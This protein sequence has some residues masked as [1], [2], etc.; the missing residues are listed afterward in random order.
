MFGGWVVARRGHL[1]TWLQ[2]DGRTGVWLPACQPAGHPLLPLSRISGRILWG[3]FSCRPPPQPAPLAV[4][5]RHLHPCPA[6]QLRSLS[7][8]AVQCQLETTTSALGCLAA[9]TWQGTVVA[10]R[11]PPDL[12]LLLAWAA[13]P[14]CSVAAAFD[15]P[16]PP[17]RA[18]AGRAQGGRGSAGW[19]AVGAGWLVR[20]GAGATAAP[21]P[22]CVYQT[23]EDRDLGGAVWRRRELLPATD[24]SGA[25][26]TT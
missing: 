10:R 21:R 16:F 8:S 14:V 1:A 7:S 12:P 4:S 9:P 6:C 17:M 19:V 25:L 13:A 24:S 5:P 15:A 2:S 11:R 20:A 23:A 3:H 26:R 18:S 22:K